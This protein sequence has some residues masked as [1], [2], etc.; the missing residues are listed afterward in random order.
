[1]Y[2]K[3]IKGSLIHSL[4]CVGIVMGVGGGGGPP[5]LLPPPVGMQGWVMVLCVSISY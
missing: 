4:L 5:L 1:V 2:K 3:S